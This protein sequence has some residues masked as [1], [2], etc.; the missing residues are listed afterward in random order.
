[1]SVRPMF[2]A[3]AQSAYEDLLGDALKHAAVAAWRLAAL[4]RERDVEPCLLER[5]VRHSGFCEG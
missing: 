4:G 2:E 1:M 3:R 5:R